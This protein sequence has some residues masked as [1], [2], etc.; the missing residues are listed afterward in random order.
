MQVGKKRSIGME[1][2]E[3][4]NKA[5]TPYQAVEAAAEFLQSAGF[6]EQK[7]E[8]TLCPER[9]GAYF[10]RL[11]GT[12][13]L[14]YT[15]GEEFS[16]KDGMH[17]AAAHTDAPCLR[18]K[19]K[20]EHAASVYK[21]LDIEVYGGA[22]LNTWFDR[23][24]SVAGKVML[25]GETAYTPKT[26]L[27]DFKRPLLTVPNLA[28]HMNREVNKGVEYKPQR[29]LLPLLGMFAEG[30][31]KERYFTELLAKELSVDA[32]D[33]LDFDLTIYCSEQASLL[34]AE[35]EFVSAPRL[36]N[37]V[38]CYA[39]LCAIRDGKHKKGLRVSVLYDH[40]EIGSR[41]KQ[42]ADSALTVA[43]LERIY[44]GLGASRE[45]L[46]AALAKSLLLSVDAAHGLHPNR[47]EVY[48]PVN[49]AVLNQGVVLKI[50]SSQRYAFDTETVAIVQVLC[51]EAGV[52]YQ[53]FA[54]HGD[55]AGGGTLGPIISSWLP[56]R[57]IDIGVP[58]LAMHSARELVG[59]Q[60]IGALCNLLKRYFEDE[61]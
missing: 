39:L 7:P 20:A 48:D 5:V 61:A 37:Q 53:K 23:P 49:R 10:I 29:D 33:I 41:S 1:L 2:F 31:D 55:L 14:A 8:E 3:Y 17:V 26:V 46:Q 60:D 27:V 11:Y 47:Q 4:L 51:E 35:E 36:D 30:Q 24:L 40:E 57:A 38:S 42:G 22:I 32:A 15:V 45:A 9:G 56:M 59:K 21:R 50:N 52:L 34:G 54:N 44:A 43:L 25:R 13:L 18:I 19:P 12:G 58:M 6:A 28:I 16:E